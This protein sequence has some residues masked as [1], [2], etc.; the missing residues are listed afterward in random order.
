MPIHYNNI[1]FFSS[2]FLV[3]LFFVL[4]FGRGSSL[5]VNFDPRINLIGF[6]LYMICLIYLLGKP[7]INRI[8]RSKGVVS[9][10]FWIVLAVWLLAHLFIL[11]KGF[12]IMPYS[13]FILH[14]FAGILLLKKYHKNIVVYYEK[15]MVFLAY[16]SLIGWGIESLGGSSLLLKSPILLENSAGVSDYSLILYTLSVDP[17]RSQELYGGIF[18][19]SGCAWEPGL[20]SVMLCIAILFNIFQNKKV[21]FSKRLIV[22]LIALIT[23]FSTTGYVMTIVIFAG[24]YLFGRKINPVQRIIYLSIIVMGTLY[25]YN[26]PFISEKIDRN[27]DTQS[28]S[29]EEASYVWYEKEGRAYT[30]G[31]FEGIVLDYM[32]FK[33]KPILGYGIMRENSYIYRKISPVIITSNGIMKPFAMFGIVL[34]FILLVITYKSTVKLSNEYLFAPP[35]LLF[36]VIILGSVSY[37][38]DSTPIMRAIQLYSLYMPFKLRQVL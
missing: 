12:P 31:R 23:T 7:N 37:M 29:T 2:R 16:V 11:D 35:Y 28:F 25:I 24:Y 6:L 10:T 15:A 18:R 8:K 19:N 14:I 5:V 27:A 26:L 30:T 3:F 34:G 17:M 13:F 38:F 21:I 20:F 9:T 22:L 32:N 33:N 1:K 36:I 4:V